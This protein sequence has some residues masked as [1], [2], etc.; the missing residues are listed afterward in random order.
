MVDLDQ[1]TSIRPRDRVHCVN[2]LARSYFEEYYLVEP[3]ISSEEIGS[4]PGEILTERRDLGDGS[5]T[6]HA[7]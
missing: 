5:R 6:S 7:G 1:D 2:S 3:A 4:I